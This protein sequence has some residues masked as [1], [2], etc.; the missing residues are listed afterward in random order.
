M[1]TYEQFEFQTLGDPETQNE[2]KQCRPETRC[3]RFE[4]NRLIPSTINSQ[5]GSPTLAHSSEHRFHQ[6]DLCA[7]FDGGDVAVDALDGMAEVLSQL[8]P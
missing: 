2:T 7:S 4:R 6:I 5:P 3:F 8:S 1:K